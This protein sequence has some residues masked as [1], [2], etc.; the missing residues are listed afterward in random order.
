MIIYVHVPKTGGTSL[1]MAAAEH[2]GEEAMLYD[3]GPE[4]PRTSPIVRELFY[5]AGEPQ[6]LADWI[7]DHH[8]EFISGHFRLDR[9]PALLPEAELITWVRDPVERV[10]SQYQHRSRFLGEKSPI[11]RFVEKK[12]WTNIMTRQTGTDASRFKV[13]GVLERHEESIAA[14]NTHLGLA[15]TSRHDNRA[16]QYE[17]LGDDLRA[18]IH[19]NNLDDYNFVKA[20]N[21]RLDRAVSDRL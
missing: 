6:R 1:R 4:A 5:E 8:V 2:F 13:I 12:R 10:R 18:K 17:P 9:Y 7:R 3:Y 14:L 21:A 15:L 20:A 11:H 19:A 16:E